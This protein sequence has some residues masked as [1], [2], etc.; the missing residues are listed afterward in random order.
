MRRW[1]LAAI[2]LALGIAALVALLRVEAPPLDDIDAASRAELER[3]LRESSA[4]GNR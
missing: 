4:E 2:G 1:L 3:L